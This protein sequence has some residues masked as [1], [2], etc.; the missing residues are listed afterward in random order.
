MSRDLTSKERESVD[1]LKQE[2]NRLFYGCVIRVTADWIEAG[3]PPNAH[4]FEAA[5]QLFHQP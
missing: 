5:R 1:S 4:L 2:M 3:R